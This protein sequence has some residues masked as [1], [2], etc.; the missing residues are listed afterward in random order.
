MQVTADSGQDSADVFVRVA[1]TQMGVEAD[2]HHRQVGALPFAA[3]DFLVQVR[4]QVL[5]AGGLGELVGAAQWRQLAGLVFPQ[6][7]QDAG[8]QR[9]QYKRADHLVAVWQVDQPLGA[10]QH[11]DQ[12]NQGHRCRQVNRQQGEGG[13]RQGIEPVA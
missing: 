8:Q 2:H 11:K 6:E 1:V 5:P 7:H 12:Q 13:Q 4:R 10:G 3:L 9:G